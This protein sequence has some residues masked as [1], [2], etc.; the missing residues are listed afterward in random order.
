MAK[1]SAFRILSV[2]SNIERKKLFHYLQTKFFSNRK[3]LAPLQQA[4]QR[5]QGKPMDEEKLF[6]AALPKKQFNKRDWYLLLSRMQDATEDFLGVQRYREDPMQQRLNTLRVYRQLKLPVFFERS[7]R[8]AHKL[9][10]KHQQ[11]GA[12]MLLWDY[13][14]ETEYFDFIASPKLGETTNLQAVS[15]RLDHYFIAEK[16]RQACLAFGRYLA[17][18]E[19]YEIRY[20]DEVLED[21]EARPDLFKVPAIVLYATCYQAVV[22]GATEQ[23]FLRLRKVLEFYH[24]RFPTAEIRAVYRLAIDRSHLEMTSGK[25]EFISLTQSLYQDGLVGGYLLEDNYLPPDTFTNI[26]GLGLKLANYDGVATFIQTYTSK[27]PGP[28]REPVTNYNLA[29]LLHAQEAYAPALKALEAVGTKEP[30]LLL[31]TMSLQSRI[32]AELRE[33]DAAN[34]ILL[35]LNTYLQRRSD[36]GQRGEASQLFLFFMAHLQQLNS[37]DLE[38]KINLQLEIEGAPEFAEK[39]WLL[40]QLK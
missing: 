36:L 2:L 12:Q 27:L 14:T 26:V 6:K 40:G 30:F 32:F 5:M 1:P 15:D 20:L 39:K 16:L 24:D 23:D 8:Q 9:R 10:E 34:E 7:F 25:Q 28:A 18:Q 3:E 4:W 13:Q 33:W 38:D 22:A 11:A 21:L 37:D 29:R 31:D 17:N 35:K 19:E